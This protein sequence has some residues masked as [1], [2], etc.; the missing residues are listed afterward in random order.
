MKLAARS[1]DDGLRGISETGYDTILRALADQDHVLRLPMSVEM[2]EGIDPCAHS[3]R[4]AERDQAVSQLVRYVVLI[5]LSR[6]IFRLTNPR[7]CDSLL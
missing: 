7:A 2:V 4:P 1:E 6:L 5:D 3:V